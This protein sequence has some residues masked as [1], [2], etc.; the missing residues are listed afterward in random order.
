MNE[1]PTTEQIFAIIMADYQN[2]MGVNMPNFGRYF[3]RVFAMINAHLFYLLYVRLNFVYRNILPDTATTP[4]HGGSLYRFGLL[5]LQRLPYNATQ[6]VYLIEGIGA[7]GSV[8]PAG[9]TFTNSRNSSI[10]TNDLEFT[11]AVG[12]NQFQIRSLDAGTPARLMVGDTI[13]I[14]S[15]VSGVENQ[16]IV[17]SEI[18]EPTDAEPIESY[19]NKI[20]TAMRYR[21]RGGAAI[22]YRFWGMQVL[23]VR[24]VYPYTGAT[25]PN[26]NLY[27]E[28]ETNNGVPS[29]ALLNDVEN[30]IET[31]RPMGN[32]ASYLPVVLMNVD[33]YIQGATSLTVSDKQQIEDAVKQ[34]LNAKRPFIQAIDGSYR[35]DRINLNEII[36]LIQGVK[37]SIYFGNISLEINNTSQTNYMLNNGQIPFLNSINY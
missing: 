33:L 24:N 13:T 19:R 27:I 1:I 10:F 3:I 35:N 4:Q 9:R 23:G 5:Y 32:F 16:F 17:V 2:R 28:S 14:V 26:I 31:R 36:S 37:P 6:G 15:P 29:P 22:D 7:V 18:T 20:I 25:N 34:Y 8:I 11:F 12:I 21:S 30:Y